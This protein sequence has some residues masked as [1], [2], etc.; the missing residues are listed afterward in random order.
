MVHRAPIINSK[1]LNSSLLHWFLFYYQSE[2]GEK[3][4]YEDFPNEKYLILPGLLNAS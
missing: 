4:C 2:N 1:S 3:R